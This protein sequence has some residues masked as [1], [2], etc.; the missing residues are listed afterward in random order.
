[1]SVI[2]CPRCQTVNDPDSRFCG[3][4]GYPFATPA[5]ANAPPQPAP[6]PAAGYTP[7]Q[8]A[9][10]QAYPPP[11]G[12]YA[13]PGPGPQPYPYPVP[14]A[15]KK[16]GSR[17]YYWLAVLIGVLSLLRV[18]L[19]L[20]PDSPAIQSTSGKWAIL[21]SG[22]TGVQ[23]GWAANF[24]AGER[25]AVVTMSAGDNE[26]EVRVWDLGTGEPKQLQ[27]VIQPGGLLSWTDGDMVNN[28]QS[29]LYILFSGGKHLTIKA[30]MTAQEWEFPAVGAMAIGDFDADGRQE[31]TARVSDD[32]GNAQL[33][34]YRYMPDQDGELLAQYQGIPAEFGF[35]RGTRGAG[36]VHTIAGR[37]SNPDRITQW[38]WDGNDLVDDSSLVLPTGANTVWYVAG[39]LKGNREV[40]VSSHEDGQ[41]AWVL[42]SEHQQGQFVQADRIELPAHGAW[43]AMAGKFRAGDG[44]IAL[45]N[46]D[47]G[48]YLILGEK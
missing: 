7:L 29:A 14:P 8:P 39:T 42:V 41:A 18:I 31:L 33:D 21:A 30:D 20:L 9:A 5:P 24:R 17:W 10:P 37:Q 35:D 27:Q 19:G 32:D 38:R 12:H 22:T 11:A 40:M 23:A 36:G 1:M 13:A 44:E 3:A 47:T 25:D 34:L 6:P 28:G 16:Q 2:A 4:C 48:E 46:A 15:P 45:Y 26:T 43:I